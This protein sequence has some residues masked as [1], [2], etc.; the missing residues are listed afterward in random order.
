M[1]ASQHG[2]RRGA[3]AQLTYI[4]S[5]SWIHS[6]VKNLVTPSKNSFVC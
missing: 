2:S 1:L 3:F 5:I 6:V 4:K